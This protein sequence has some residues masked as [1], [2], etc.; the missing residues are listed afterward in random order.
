MPSVARIGDLSSVFSGCTQDHAVQGSP[1]SFA[2]GLG[3]HRKTDMWSIHCC[4][5]NNCYDAYLSAGAATTFVNGLNVG[6]RGDPITRNHKISGPRPFQSAFAT[7]GTGSPD[8]FVGGPNTD[9][10]NNDGGGGGGITYFRAGAA[11]SGDRLLA[12]G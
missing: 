1:D 10:G 3:V 8:T 11:R 12:F 7:V 5:D 4:A 6:R 9:G 2:N